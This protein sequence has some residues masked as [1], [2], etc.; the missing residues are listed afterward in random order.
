[1]L[2]P[3][4]DGCWLGVQVW[5]PT[6]APFFISNHLLSFVCLPSGP[7]KHLKRL[8]WLGMNQAMSSLASI[9]GSRLL[10]RNGGRDASSGPYML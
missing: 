5:I 2:L 7:T 3:G 1:M 6:V 8:R 10:V 9:L 4:F